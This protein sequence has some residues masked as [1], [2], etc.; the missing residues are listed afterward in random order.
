ME[1]H[2][3]RVRWY[4][5][6]CHGARCVIDKLEFFLAVAQTENFSRAAELCGVTQP[7][8]SA[9]IRQLEGTL[10]AIL[11]NRSSRYHGLTAEGERVREWAR[12]IVA[13]TRAMKQDVRA[14]RS[15]IVGHLRIA[16]IPTA[17]A[18]VAHLTTPYREKHAGVRFSIMSQTSDKIIRMIEDLEADA[19]LTYLDGEPLGRMLQVPIYSERYRLITSEDSPL[20]DRDAVTWAE[21]GRIPLCLLTPDMQNRR[22]IDGLLRQAGCEPAPTLE[23]NSIVALYSHVRTGR[24]ATV[25]AEHL[26]ETLGVTDRVRAIPIIN[27]DVSHRIG[28]V[29]HPR[30]P[31]PP[32]LAALVTEAKVCAARLAR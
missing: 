6:K 10:G 13:D 25:M 19:G 8:L 29:L 2:D 30:E 26:A 3:C 27:P 12:R 9:G 20:G 17:L 4:E 31:M 24:W 1:P 5:G 14:A 15:S 7:T 16:A 32:M 21:V 28:L 22:I 23:S 11:I 18:M